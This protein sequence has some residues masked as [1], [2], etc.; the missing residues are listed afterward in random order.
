M[1][2]RVKTVEIIE[3]DIPAVRI[4]QP[5]KFEDNRGFF[6]ESYNQG[7]LKKLGIETIFV[8]DNHSSS[9]KK[10]TVRGLHYQIEPQAQVKLVRVIRGA[11]VDV[12]VDIRPDSPTRGQ[13][14]KAMLS[15]ENMRQLLV[16]AGFAHGFC[17]LENDTEVL[18]KT[19]ALYS[20]E[21][22]RGILWEDPDL[23]IDWQIPNQDIILSDRDTKFPTLAEQIDF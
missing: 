6:Y 9:I 14:V 18:Y 2:L 3:T 1:E 22:E 17:T 13:Y 10:G 20:P 7:T 21:H 12:A 15:A 16:P 5:R 8:Q 19:S 4:L 23:N 11:V